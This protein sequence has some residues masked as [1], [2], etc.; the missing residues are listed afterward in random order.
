VYTVPGWHDALLPTNGPYISPGL[1]IK[2]SD[3]IGASG[4]GEPDSKQHTS[5]PSKTGPKAIRTW[6]ATATF[7]WLAGGHPGEEDDG[8]RCVLQVMGGWVLV[9]KEKVR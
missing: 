9:L 4:S 6:Q 5:Q 7:H 2:V 8:S 3:R 1:R